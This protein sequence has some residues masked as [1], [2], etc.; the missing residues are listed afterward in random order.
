MAKFFLTNNKTFY[1]LYKKIICNTNFN[2]SFDYSDELLFAVACHK[3]GMKNLNYSKNKSDFS[4]GIGTCIYKESLDY[5]L[6]LN[7]YNGNIAKIRNATIGQYGVVIKKGKQITIYGDACGCYDIF[8]YQD[9]SPNEKSWIVSNSLYDMAEVLKGKITLNEFSV[10]E[11]TVNR[12]LMGGA[13]FFDEIYRLRGDE[14]IEMDINAKLQINS[15]Q[16]SFLVSDEKDYN[17]IVV[18]VANVLRENARISAKIFGVPTICAT[19]G[20]D[21][22]LVI[23]A[24]LSAGIKPCLFY[25]VGNNMITSPRKEDEECIKKLSKS[26]GLKLIEGDFSVSEPLDKDWNTYIKDNGFTAAFMWG[27]QSKVIQSL[28]SGTDLLLFGWGG[29]LLR[30]ID[31]WTE[32]NH[33]KRITLDE[34]NERWYSFK[35]SIPLVQK[36][37]PQYKEIIKEHLIT[38]CRYLGINPDD[39]SIEDSF[40]IE[41]A[42]R[43]IADTQIPSFLNQYKYTYLS[44]FEYSL[45]Q[46]RTSVCCKNSTRFMLEV[47]YTLYPKIF[48]IPIFSHCQWR[49][50]DKETIS[51]VP[52]KSTYNKLYS[53]TLSKLLRK[54]AP[55]T[56]KKFFLRPVN[57]IAMQFLSKPPQILAPECAV[58]HF[59]KLNDIKYNIDFSD[60]RR[61]ED[62]V[63]YAILLRA[64][65]SLGF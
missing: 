16:T 46:C 25:G 42:Y 38:E 55:E 36:K 39:M 23:A 62:T 15:I 57:K 7:D 37:I 9:A 2:L 26:L 53:T 20:L 30:N 64:L 40:L 61:S 18:K 49:S 41:L 47:I 63:M 58:N 6:L 3:I 31:G 4:L 60:V 52:Y 32:K 48:S 56:I 28:C 8:Y 59:D 54:T 14:Y 21:S 22:R 33:K 17:K 12:A 24:Y 45:L 5:S 1:Q 13:T 10:I 35:A 51:L 27:A 11:R 29:E 43:G 44:I 34:L 19:G 65:K 50:F